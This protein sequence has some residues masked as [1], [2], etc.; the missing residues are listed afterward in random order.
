MGSTGG[1]NVSEM[2][3]VRDLSLMLKKKKEN[4]IIHSFFEKFKPYA[5]CRKPVLNRDFELTE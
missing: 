3:Q 2:S 5:G 4:W 1:K